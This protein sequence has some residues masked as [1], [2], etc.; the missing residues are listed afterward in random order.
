MKTLVVYESRYGNTAL[1]ARAVA[2]ALR[3]RGSA[4][5]MPVDEVAATDLDGVDL[6][7]VGG[8]T[9]AHGI[10]AELS[11]WLKS[12]PVERV[13]GLP[14]ATFDTRY[15]MA[16]FLTG[17][18][19]RVALRRLKHLGATPIAAPESFFVIAG[20]GPLVDGENERAIAWARGLVEPVGALRPGAL[21]PQHAA[22]GEH[23]QPHA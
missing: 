6:L 23:W 13:D 4:H 10:S 21:I 14:F 19:A 7:V 12:L 9:H 17:S 22:P 5:L 20:E 11:G 18:A 16:Q 3:E 8:P 2:D 1:I 15:H